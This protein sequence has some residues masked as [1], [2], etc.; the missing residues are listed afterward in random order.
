MHAPGTLS[1]ADLQL[2]SESGA[3]GTFMGVSR[4]AV[5]AAL[6]KKGGRIGLDF[7]IE[8]DIDSPEFSLDE[9]LSTRL[10]YSLAETLGVGL[11][12]LVEGVGTLGQK[13][14]EAAGEAA[15]GV[16]EMFQD[17]FDDEPKR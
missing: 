1:L 15:R 12:G 10:A 17:L 14:G 16:S 11:S 5:I 3:L 13:G 9:A 7:T 6:E 4:G 2:E 8:G